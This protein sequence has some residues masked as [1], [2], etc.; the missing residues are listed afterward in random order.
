M[1]PK[2]KKLLNNFFI[3]NYSSVYKSNPEL[4]SEGN[5]YYYTI[6][7]DSNIICLLPILRL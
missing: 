2:L 1:D 4:K 5:D 7:K 3:E 6:N